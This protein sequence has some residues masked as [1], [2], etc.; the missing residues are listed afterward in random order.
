M[1]LSERVRSHGN[2]LLAESAPQI[3]NYKSANANKK[4]WKNSE[5]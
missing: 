1:L 4:K 3:T 2:I 5:I